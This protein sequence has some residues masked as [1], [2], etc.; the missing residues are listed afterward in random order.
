MVNPRFCIG[1]NVQILDGPFS[2]FS[3][4]FQMSK[5]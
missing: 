1:D 3:A 2:G 4:V 5:A